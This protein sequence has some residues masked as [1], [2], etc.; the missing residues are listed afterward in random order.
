MEPVNAIICYS[1]TVTL[2]VAVGGCGAP[3]GTGVMT[4]GV[5]R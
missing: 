5:W 2:A 3:A 1:T 4:A